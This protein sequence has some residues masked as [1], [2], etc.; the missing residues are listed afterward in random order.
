[1]VKVS[2]AVVRQHP[3]NFQ[4]QFTIVNEGS[5]TINGWELVVVLP[6]DDIRSVWDASFHTSGG[7]L[8]IEPLPS[9]RSIPPGATVT[10]NL[11]AHG[12]TPAPTSCTFNG[13]PC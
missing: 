10:E 6:G 11:S 7:T 4:G 13:S 8:Y 5:T 9:Q 2:Y 12:S 1:M 3:N